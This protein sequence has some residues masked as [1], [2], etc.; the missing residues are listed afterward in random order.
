MGL[1]FHL[2]DA[3][4]LVPD[5]LDL[6]AALART[7]HLAVGAHPDDLEILAQAGI[8]ACRH[9][10]DAWFAGIVASD[11]AGSPR[12]GRYADMT[13]ARMR[14]V[15]WDEQAA[16]AR[17]GGYG[18]CVQLAYPSAVL[19]D[20]G[21]PRCGEDLAA[22]L[23]AARPTVLYTHNPL[24]RHDT[25]VAVALRTLAAVR[26]LPRDQRPARVLGCEVWRDL[27]WLCDGDRVAL[28]TGP[29]EA[30]Q[31][32]LLALFDSQVAG[33]KRYDLATLGRRRAHA[34]FHASHGVDGPRGLTFA[35]D[36]TPL[37]DDPDLD[38]VTFAL[39]AIDRFRAEAETRL[40]RL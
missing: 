14:E 15:R 28:D 35:L 18:A 22:L 21:D 24:D 16:A 33:G 7:T 29:D 26:R 30:F 17:L 1:S 2:A 11:G 25:H 20:P 23:A 19:K 39:G 4:H 36:L 27:D 13:D 12:A 8:E 5:G 37:A 3:R 40:R 34:T 32:A 9:R 31:T 6:A 38:P 10:G